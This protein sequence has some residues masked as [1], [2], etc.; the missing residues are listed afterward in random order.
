MTDKMT[1]LFIKHTSHILAAVTR[2][3]D[4]TAKI[5]A[6]ELAR[7]GLLVRGLVGSDAQFEVPP[8]ELDIATVD[9]EPT[10]LLQPRAFFI[11]EDQE[12]PLPIISGAT[13]NTVTLTATT[14]TVKPDNTPVLNDTNVWVLITGG[15]LTQP[16]I[17]KGLVQSGQPSTAFPLVPLEAGNYDVL[18]FVATR[19]PHVLNHSIP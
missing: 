8:G 5:S 14:V 4:P 12:P 18:T 16:Q 1:L 11:D 15:N 17:A 6:E 7:G 2:N 10:L 19:Q 9:L 13:V 3:A